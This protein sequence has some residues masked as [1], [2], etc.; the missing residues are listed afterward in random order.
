M[1]DKIDMVLKGSIW[2]AQ[3]GLWR[4]FFLE[5]QHALSWWN[6]SSNGKWAFGL[7]WAIDATL[8][9]IR[10]YVPYK[11]EAAKQSLQECT[12]K[13]F[14]EWAK[15]PERAMLYRGLAFRL[16]E[17]QSTK[18]SDEA[19]AEMRKNFAQL[20]QS[21]VQ[22]Q[23]CWIDTFLATKLAEFDQENVRHQVRERVLFGPYRSEAS[24]QEM[25]KKMIASN[26][27]PAAIHTAAAPPLTLTNP[28]YGMAGITVDAKHNNGQYS[29]FGRPIVPL[30]ILPK[31]TVLPNASTAT[32][33]M[34]MG[35]SYRAPMRNYTP[36]KMAYHA[37]Q[38]TQS[39]PVHYPAFAA[40]TCLPQ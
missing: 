39:F 9:M 33:P 40:C 8:D 27:V 24:Y 18:W 21:F 12:A 5:T 25:K 14:G 31:A 22:I 28:A 17:K 26:L 23:D 4:Q 38:R 36:I 1:S 20:G 6:K 2:S 35:G 37:A 29:H 11:F 10:D 19:K 13:V 16:S 32:A 30:Q 15:Y 7:S 34:K 3:Q